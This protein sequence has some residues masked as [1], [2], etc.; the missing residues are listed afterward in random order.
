MRPDAVNEVARD[1][2]TVVRPIGRVALRHFSALAGV[3][4][5]DGLKRIGS[6]FFDMRGGRDG[7]IPDG[8]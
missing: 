5:M 2:I 8:M 1:A 4:R 3:D 6:L 7:V